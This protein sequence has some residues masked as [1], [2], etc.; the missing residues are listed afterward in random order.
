VAS[1]GR[2][3]KSGRSQD[4]GLGG[5]HLHVGPVPA[6]ARFRRATEPIGPE[7]ETLRA[8]GAAGRAAVFDEARPRQ[9]PVH[10][11]RYVMRPRVRS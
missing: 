3:R 5:A 1:N 2:V 7:R 4:A 10:L 8:L 6:A 9:R 11:Y